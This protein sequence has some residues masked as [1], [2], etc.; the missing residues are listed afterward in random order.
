MMW[1]TEFK[2]MVDQS[3]SVHLMVSEAYDKNVRKDRHIK[4]I[5]EIRLPTAIQEV[6]QRGHREESVDDS[7]MPEIFWNFAT[8]S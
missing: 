6:V 8:G 4:T 7:P 3:T 1:W 2:R 5:W